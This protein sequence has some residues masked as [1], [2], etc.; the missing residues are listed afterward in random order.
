VAT[1]P[2]CGMFVDEGSS[3]LYLVRS[4]RT[5]YFCSVGCLRSFASP[6]AER[7]ELKR[8]LAVAWPLS[9]AIVVLT[10]GVASAP[11]LWAS[12]ALAAVVQFYPGAVFYAGAR[13]ALRQRLGNMDLLIAVGTS[14]AFAYSV[15]TL[16]VP[17]RLPPGT[18]FDASA[19]II[20][21]ILTG[22]F[23]ERLTRARAGSALLRLGEL[24]PSQ[25]CVVR[26]GTEQTV[27]VSA[28]VPG[29][30]LR[31][32]PGERFPADGIVREGSTTVDESILTGE[33]LPIRRGPGDR[34]LAGSM[35]V[36]GAIEV[37]AVGAGS[38]T[39]L[40]QVGRLLT[41]AESS[42]LPLRR[43]ADRIASVFVPL[44]LGLAIAASLFWGVAEHAGAA[45]TVLVFVTV[46]IT[47]CPCAFGIATPAA[48]LVGTGRAAEEGVLFRGEEAIER[49]ARVDLVLTDKTGTLTT[50][51]PEVASIGV[52]PPASEADI[53]ALAAGL[54]RGANHP[55]ARAVA[56]SARERTVAAAPVDEVR[57]EPGRGVRG[58]WG[59]RSVALVRGDAAEAEGIDLTPLRGW[60]GPVEAAG[61]SWSVLVESGRAVGGLAF[62][63]ALAP[64][65]RDAVASI[66]SE[67]ADVGIVT[68]DNERAA[69]RVAEELGIR[70]VHAAADPTRKVELVEQ[71]KRSGRRVAFVG[72]GVNDA[73]A[74]ASADLGIAIG[75]GTDVAREAGQ[76]LLVRS[77]FSG[78]PRA[79]ALARRTVAQVRWNLRWAI[80]Y[81]LVLLPVAAGALVPL[82]GLGVYGYLPIV[83][84]VAMGL[85]STTVV[86]ASFALRWTHAGPTPRGPGPADRHAAPS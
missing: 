11:A 32:T 58:R 48:I 83:G 67:G 63:V 16:V 46:A 42:R 75:S 64:G 62:R 30:R 68:G 80:G 43:T 38:D 7:R 1:D 10:Y 74:L 73:A 23:L 27:A 53:L 79:I 61:D 65:V 14:A 5:Y 66:R 18:Y 3:S 47:A 28:I 6:E 25:A 26:G 84:A 37:D 40:A 15:A 45:V 20:T 24:L 36:D 78:V 70:I 39:F 4:N 29:D 22:N 19:L 54:E 21:L 34:V 9:L 60:I 33:P 81:N 85:S 82:L 76:V 2:V 59:A 71:Y 41:D 56:S 86:L 8:K 31:V 51:S 13:D 44:V 50:L 52:V 57:V 35:N 72:D 69:R 77:E 55:L 12:A 17:G 49:A